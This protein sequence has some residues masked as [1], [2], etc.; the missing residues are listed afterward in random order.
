[1]VYD[2]G[3]PVG[4]AYGSGLLWA[5]AGRT[6]VWGAARRALRTLRVARIL[7]TIKSAK[8][9]RTLLTTLLYS[10]PS[11]TNIAL[12]FVLILV[13]LFVLA[14]R[15]GFPDGLGLFFVV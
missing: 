1:M 12:I 7:R 11:L 6:A 8:G 10:L 15:L 9:L 13:R 4:A 3:G 14:A 5:A 2:G